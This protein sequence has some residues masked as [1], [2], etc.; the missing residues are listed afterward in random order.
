MPEQEIKGGGEGGGERNEQKLR[1]EKAMINF[2]FG[3]GG[4]LDE[5]QG[6]DKYYRNQN[7]G[8]HNKRSASGTDGLRDCFS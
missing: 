7:I 6:Q 2:F 4:G 1:K 3:G 5:Q 8:K